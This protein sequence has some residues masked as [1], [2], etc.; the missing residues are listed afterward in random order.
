MPGT[1]V[2]IADGLVTGSGVRAGEPLLWLEAMKMQHRI[3][4]P[5]TGTVTAVQVTEG[6]QV[7]VGTLLAVVENTQP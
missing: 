6:Q 1:V 2:K 3:S 5:V 7:E 4:A